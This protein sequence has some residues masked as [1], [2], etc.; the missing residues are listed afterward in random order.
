MRKA[1]QTKKRQ[2]I[3]EKW[4][5]ILH[6]NFEGVQGE[7]LVSFELLTQGTRPLNFHCS[8]ISSLLMQ[9]IQKNFPMDWEEKVQTS[10]LSSKN[11]FAQA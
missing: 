11:L 2:T 6:P 9:R 7:V 1:F 4:L 3:D 8:V 10:I 5:Q